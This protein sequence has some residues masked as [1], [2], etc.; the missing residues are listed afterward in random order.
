MSELPTEL[1]NRSYILFLVRTTVHISQRVYQ[2]K[3]LS[4]PKSKVRSF[5]LRAKDSTKD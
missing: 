4:F 1:T 3:Q 2:T 5:T